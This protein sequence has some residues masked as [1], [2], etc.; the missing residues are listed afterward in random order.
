MA[1][2]QVEQAGMAGRVAVR[3]PERR[4]LFAVPWRRD[5]EFAGGELVLRR[6]AR[7]CQRML[8]GRSR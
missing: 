8:G 6:A 7:D 1:R 2:L 5:N 4:P 3:Y